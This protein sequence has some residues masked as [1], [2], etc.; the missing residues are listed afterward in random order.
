MNKKNFFVLIL[1]LPA[2]IAGIW[3]MTS[4]VDTFTASSITVVSLVH[5]DGTTTEY[6]DEADKE[7]FAEFNK[8]IVSIEKQEYNPEVYSMYQLGFERVSGDVKYS[9][10]LSADIKNC[11]AFD[12]HGN[13][14]RIDKEYAKK[15]LAHNDVSEVYR[16]STVPILLF[17]ANQTT[18]EIT[19][20]N[21]D[22]YYLLADETYSNVAVEE[23]C[24]DTSFCYVLSGD[25]FEFEFD[26][27]PDW[28]N[29][30]I[31]D[32]DSMVYD[33][34]LNSVT[35]FSYNKESKLRAVISA[36]WYEDTTALYHG[37]ATY[38]VYFDYDIKSICNVSRDT[39]TAGDAVYITLSNADGEELEITS[40]I[41]SIEVLEL[42]NVDGK[43]VIVVPVP[44]STQTG[45]YKVSIKS[46]RTDISVSLNVNARDYGTSKIGFVASE[47]AE[48]YNSA[49]SAFI[50]E[51]SDTLAVDA[52]VSDA[53]WFNGLLTPVSKYTNG[54]K[55]YTFYAPSYGVKQT[56]NGVQL[57]GES[58][59]IHYVKL[60]TAKALS[61]RSVAN[62]VVV[63]SGNTLLYGNT[64]IV[65]HGLG[66]KSVYGHLENLNFIVGDSVQTGTSLGN[67]K[68][69]GFAVS[70]TELFF[71][72]CIGD[73]F[74]NPNNFVTEPTSAQD[75]ELSEPIAL[76]SN[77]L[78]VE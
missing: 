2:I 26:V 72:V 39:V 68:P 18:R 52:E 35:E 43:G 15:F 7:F 21:A 48:E 22:W 6:T 3:L 47:T 58:L 32:G 13:W 65:D 4:S 46:D 50:N 20:T 37:E 54:I 61:V 69:S 66:F 27:Q 59:G 23:E 78:S 77:A 45:E 51:I 14:Y 29:V 8:S 73:I 57:D 28:Y 19:A 9:L 76:L 71:G 62:G 36:E 24:K 16:N 56:M 1:F 63:F 12:E 49:F 53:N 41:P 74:L 17:T 25:G 67:A 5:P 33:G 30:K 75:T 31:Y 55:Q 11:L 44:M 40:D 42:H 34:L 64:V 60:G 38:T 10:C 70:S